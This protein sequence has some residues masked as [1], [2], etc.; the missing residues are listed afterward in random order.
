MGGIDMKKHILAVAVAALAM[1]QLAAAQDHDLEAQLR[2]FLAPPEMVMRFQRQLDIN[3]EQRQAIRQKITDLQTEIMDLQW[4][5]QDQGQ[6]LVELVRQE[7]ADLSAALTQLDRVL[8]VESS[9][10]KRH[11][12]MLLEI[13]QILNTEQRLRLQELMEEMA[14]REMRELERRRPEHE[15]NSLQQG[16]TRESHEH[17]PG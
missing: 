3:D 7:A 13:R 16:H 11:M 9:I 12:Q 8:E 14:L 6:V 15:Q 2:P 17:I 4:D 5:L 10:K 1:P